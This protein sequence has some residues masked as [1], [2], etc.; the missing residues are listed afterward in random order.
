MIRIKGFIIA[1]TMI[2]LA[3][4]GLA[5]NDITGLM[6]GLLMS[7]FLTWLLLSTIY[8]QQETVAQ[9]QNRLDNTTVR[10]AEP[11]IRFIIFPKEMALRR[12][13]T[14]RVIASG[15]TTGGRSA[16]GVPCSVAWSIWYQLTPQNMPKDSL[17]TN[18]NQLLNNPKD[19]LDPLVGAVLRGMVSQK[20]AVYLAS[21]QGWNTLNRQFQNTLQRQVHQEGFTIQK[22]LVEGIT[23]PTNMQIAMDLASVAEL[24]CQKAAQ[25]GRHFQKIAGR[26]TAA[27][28]N[29]IRG[30]HRLHTMKHT[31]G[32]ANLLLNSL[33]LK[34]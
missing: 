2:V 20:L 22:A 11:G 31:I 12:I 28:T 16:D 26:R 7:A 24:V 25:A 4:T 32:N 8:V 14:R 13:S 29:L 1:V 5:L 18:A 34:P 30:T 17:P 6:A 23:F 21:E 9:I 19:V 27:E 10:I 3:A 33:N 15:V